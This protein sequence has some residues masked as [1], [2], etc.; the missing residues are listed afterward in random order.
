MLILNRKVNFIIY[1]Y[2]KKE[3][4]I[5]SISSD[6]SNFVLHFIPGPVKRNVNYG[7]AQTSAAFCIFYVVTFLIVSE[8][9]VLF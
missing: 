7:V 4:P 6:F 1:F 2:K 3:I 9:V 5:H 8:N